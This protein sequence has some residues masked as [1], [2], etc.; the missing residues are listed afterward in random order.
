VVV[1]H[2]EADEAEQ[3]ETP[4]PVG[5]QAGA[6]TPSTVAV[7]ASGART[8]FGAPGTAGGTLNRP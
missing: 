6:T 3:P 1:R 2:Q 7:L 5:Q 4:E 8:A